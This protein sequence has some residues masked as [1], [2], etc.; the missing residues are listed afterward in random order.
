MFDFKC[1]NVSPQLIK[2]ILIQQCHKAHLCD[3]Q[4][5]KNEICA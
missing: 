5:A 1:I 2:K 3:S 4:Q